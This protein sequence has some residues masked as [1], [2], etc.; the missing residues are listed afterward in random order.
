VSVLVLERY[1]VSTEAAAE[2]EALL[3]GHLGLLRTQPGLLWAEGARASDE[4][5]YV[6]LTEWRTAADLDAWEASTA[7]GAFGESVDHHLAGDVSRRR[8]DPRPA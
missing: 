1:P 4:G 8:F 2:F 3:S 5:N 7:A 6:L